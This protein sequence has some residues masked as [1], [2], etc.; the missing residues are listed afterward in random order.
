MRVQ[1]SRCG[2]RRRGG[3][4]RGRHLQPRGLAAENRRR[5]SA[6]APASRTCW[7][8]PVCTQPRYP[9]SFS[10]RPADGH[11]RRGLGLA[12]R[13]S[14]KKVAA[15]GGLFAVLAYLT[16]SG[17]HPPAQ[18]GRRSPPASPSSPCCLIAGRLACGR[19]PPPHLIV[20]LLQ[21]EAVVQPGFQMSF[22]ATA[23]SGGAGGGLAASPSQADL[24]A[25]A[26]R[27]HPE[28]RRIGWSASP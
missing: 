11:R 9:D 7:R 23:A 21:P 25:L 12:L 19:W 10:W 1:A 13:V 27:H 28:R 2:R 24:R 20:L 17:A 16:L 26:H 8:S 5:R 4:C 18:A 3:P 15:A 6:R 22:S 14:G